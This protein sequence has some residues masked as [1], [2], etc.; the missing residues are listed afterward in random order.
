MKIVILLLNKMNKINFWLISIGSLLLFFML[1]IDLA[2]V[3]GVKFG[4]EVVPAGKTFIE[5]FMAVLVY[6]GMAYVLLERGHIKTEILQKHF[7][8]PFRFAS[9]ALSYLVIASTS[10][11]IFWINIRVAIDCFQQNATF[12]DKILVP[13]GPFILTI[14]ISFL[15]L[16]LCAVLLLIRD[17]LSKVAIQD[18]NE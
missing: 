15:S 5:E 16:A 7:L 18:N 9:D 13:I 1:A 6:I 14:S 3:I 11:F 12:P 8:P 2:N 17:C 4:K 10:A